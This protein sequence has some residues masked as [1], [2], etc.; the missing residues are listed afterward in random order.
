LSL[1]LSSIHFSM[2][3]WLNHQLPPILSTGISFG[4]HQAVNAR[5]VHPKPSRELSE[6]Q[7]W[8]R[9]GA[10]EAMMNLAI[11]TMHFIALV[12]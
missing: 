6:R 4:S 10:V 8:M 9:R 3:S 1:I 7:Q 12:C 2:A 11:N 5:W